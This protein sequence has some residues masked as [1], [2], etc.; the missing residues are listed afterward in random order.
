MPTPISVKEASLKKRARVCAICGA[1][2]FVRSPE[3]VGRTCSKEC[4]R[5]NISAIQTGKTRSAE[6]NAKRSESMKRRLADPEKMMKFQQATTAGIRKWLS[7]PVNA[8]KFA[9]RSSETM[10]KRH[11]DPEFQKR[12]DKRSSETMKRNWIKYRD[13]FTKVAVE[14]YAAGLG[15]NSDESKEK[16]NVAAKWIMK[17]CRESMILETDYIAV[18]TDTLNR[19]RREFPYDGPKDG[20]DYTDYLSKLGRMVTNSPE[21]RMIAD[22]FMKAAIPR[23]SAAWQGMKTDAYSS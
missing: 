5:K 17:K 23:F 7:D 10:K 4:F 15:I 14:R 6:S 2:F 18:F 20:S 19:L 12:R 1:H 22:T 3:R 21:C 16:K 11:T 9:A 8:A 13:T